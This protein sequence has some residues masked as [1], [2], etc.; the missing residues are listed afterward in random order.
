MKGIHNLTVILP[1]WV[2]VKNIKDK[3]QFKNIKDKGQFLRR[4][5]EM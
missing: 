2:Q 5:N 4:I 1:N 3:G